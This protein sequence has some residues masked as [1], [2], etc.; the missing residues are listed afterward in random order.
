MERKMKPFSEWEW[1]DMAWTFPDILKEA[2]KT[3]LIYNV[4]LL[5]CI[6]VLVGLLFSIVAIPIAGVLTIKAVFV[7]II[8]LCRRWVTHNRNMTLLGTTESKMKPFFE[9]ERVDVAW[10]FP[11]ILKVAMKIKLTYCLLL[12]CFIIVI[13][14]LLLCI[15]IIPINVMLTIN[16]VL[17]DSIHL[18]RTWIS[19][20]SSVTLLGFQ[21]G[22]N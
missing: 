14:G 13:V 21:L 5:L 12:L 9:W 1:V 22:R 10:T 15:I 3:I 16:A 18:C 6:L 4:L 19:H 2:L 20:N 7:D 17:V 8:H 11:D